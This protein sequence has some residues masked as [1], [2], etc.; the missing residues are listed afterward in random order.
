MKKI[1]IN[2]CVIIIG[3]VVLASCKGTSANLQ[4]NSLLTSL[5]SSSY[6]DRYKSLTSL[7]NRKTGE[8]IDKQTSDA[9]IKMLASE[10]DEKVKTVNITDKQDNT[11]ARDLYG[12]YVTALATVVASNKI[13]GGLPILF[14]FLLST[15]YVISPAILTN[16]DKPAFD[17]IVD[18]IEKGNK[19]EKKLAISILS[20]WVSPSPDADDYDESSIPRLSEADKQKALSIFTKLIRDPDGE[21]RYRAISGLEPYL[22]NQDVKNTLKNISISDS[23]SAVRS[24][25]KR[26]LDGCEKVEH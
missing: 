5:S 22:G 19:N 13:E 14:K 18:R 23:D 20:I 7:L 6:L 16:Y 11:D 1:K 15:Q 17:Y 9:L 12:D 21:I 25:A 8:K 10:A 26:I 24:S 2:C 4:K 3:F